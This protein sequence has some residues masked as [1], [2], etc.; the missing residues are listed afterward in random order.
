MLDAEN[1]PI[2]EPGHPGIDQS[3]PAPNPTMS[4]ATAVPV[5]VQVAPSA[6]PPRDRSGLWALFGVVAGFMLPVIGCGTFFF[7]TVFSLSLAGS[8]GGAAPRA[9]GGGFGDAVAVVRVE[10]VIFAS[11][12][13]DIGTGALSGIVIADLEAAAADPS[14]KAIVL[15]VDSPGGGVTGSAQ[16][17]EAVL[18]VDKPVVV[19][20]GV[21]AASGGYYVSA[22]ADHC[23]R[24]RA[25]L[26]SGKLVG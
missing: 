3:E 10:G 20:M 8:V 23:Y 24:R 12:E 21:T 13:T 2:P 5:P 15:R 16:I 25:C 1:Q 6:A 9:T 4:D 11:D 7:I 18:E 26:G 19:S 17:Y 14:V 22:P